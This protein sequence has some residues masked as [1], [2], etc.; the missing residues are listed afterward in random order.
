MPN[1]YS[2]RVTIN[3]P[4]DA[5]DEHDIADRATLDDLEGLARKCIE[6]NPEATSFVFIVVRV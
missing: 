1:L 4:G 5:E 2:L 6:A 3:F